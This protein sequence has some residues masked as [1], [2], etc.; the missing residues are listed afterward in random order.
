M[1]HHHI[2]KLKDSKGRLRQFFWN[3]L[4]LISF[5][6]LCLIFLSLLSSKGSEMILSVVAIISSVFVIIL[7]M[8]V[9]Y[10][11]FAKKNYIFEDKQITIHHSI[12]GCKLGRSSIIPIAEPSYYF[13]QCQ[14]SAKKTTNLYTRQRSVPSLSYS[15]MLIN[16]NEKTTLFESFDK[17]KAEEF[18]IQLKQCYP[19]IKG[20]TSEG[21]LLG[22]DQQFAFY[23]ISLGGSSSN[24]EFGRT[25]PGM[26]AL[27]FLIASLI[28]SFFVYINIEKLDS[29]PKESGWVQTESELIK[30]KHSG[31]GRHTGSTAYSLIYY[32]GGER[33]HT[34]RTSSYSDI[35]RS[36]D[37]GYQLY[38]DPNKPSNYSFHLDSREDIQK[39]INMMIMISIICILLCIAF[40]IMTI[41]VWK[42]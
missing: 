35:E 17:V 25:F 33:Y 9:I 30:T 42:K 4:P 8:R 12:F 28:T 13:S 14:R 26:L 11:L 40:I 7:G 18:I 23:N 38:V 24:S 1:T 41:R 31:G 36:K 39:R 3:V 29:P 10:A 19:S 15:V 27:I 20:I 22:P 16:Q 5:M 34:L 21:Y 6:L 37:N 32:W 2:C